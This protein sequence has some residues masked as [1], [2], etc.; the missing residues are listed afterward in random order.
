[1]AGTELALLLRSSAAPGVR[2]PDT[3]V[4]QV[5]AIVDDL[6]L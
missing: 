2:F 1:M 3:T 4:I 6:L 5:D